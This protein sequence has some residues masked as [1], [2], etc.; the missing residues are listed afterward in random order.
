V[1]AFDYP[2][3]S[4]L[5]KNVYSTISPGIFFRLTNHQKQIGSSAGIGGVQG[6]LWY[7]RTQNDIDQLV[8]G[9]APHPPYIALIDPNSTEDAVAL[10][11]RS[12][13]L[14]LSMSNRVVGVV[15]VHNTVNTPL[16]ELG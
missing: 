6:V 2:D 8:G 5:E 12:N 14:S 7:I 16:G 15:I 1:K 10:S 3:F 9:V 13:L 4:N 11:S